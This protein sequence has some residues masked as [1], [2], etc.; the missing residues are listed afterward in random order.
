MFSFFKKKSKKEK[1]QAKYEK[2][3]SEAHKLST[4]NRK[5]S[6]EKVYEADLVLKEIESLP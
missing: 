4:I 6:D 5:L 3:L 1:L 2:L